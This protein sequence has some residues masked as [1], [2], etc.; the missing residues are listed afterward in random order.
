M[1]APFGRRLDVPKGGD[2]NDLSAVGDATLT[3]VVGGEK[4]L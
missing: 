4:P 2:P 3:A 1:L